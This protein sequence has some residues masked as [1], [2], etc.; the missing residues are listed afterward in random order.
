MSSKPLLDELR[1]EEK[2]AFNPRVLRR[3]LAYLKPYKGVVALGLFGL[4]ISTAATLLSPVIIQRTVDRYILIP[5]GGKALDQ[6]ARLAGIAR[7]SWFYLALLVLSLL[8]TFF[9]VYLT[10]LTS[11]NVMRDMR[12]DLF[13]RL[14]GQSMKFLGGTPVGSLV[15]RLTSDVEKINDFFTSVALAVLKDAALMAGILITLFIMNA[16]LALIVV[17]TLP[18]VIVLTLFIRNRVRDVYRAYQHHTSR[19]NAYISESVGGMDVVQLFNRAEGFREGFGERNG[20]L[21][22][23]SMDEMRLYSLFRPLVSFFTSLSL[24]CLIYFGT[25]L[26][27]SGLVTLGVLIAFI[28]LVE[29]FYQ[30][31][32]DITELITVMQSAMA[33]GE[34][35]FALM[36]RDESIPDEGT[37]APGEVKG[38]LAFDRVRFCYKENEPVLRGLSFQVKAG[39]TLAIVGTTGAGKTTVANLLARFWDRQEGSISLDGRDIRDYSLHSLRNHIQSVQQDVTLF[40]GTVRENIALGKDISDEEIGRALEIVR[41]DHFVKELP[42]GLDTTL[43]EGADNISAGQRQLL[44]FARIFVHNPSVVILDEATSSI[45]TQTETWIQEGMANLL[46]DRTALVI[47]HRLSTIRNADR[48]LV[49]GKGVLLEEGSHQELIDKGGIYFNLYKLQYE[50]SQEG[51]S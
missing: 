44:S 24:G 30:P 43:T 31:I 35:V 6:A 49:L 21:F 16:R 1:E 37:W 14:I 47:A 26:H 48:I 23:A 25:G 33:G 29:Q 8:F 38:D 51:D 34:R 18:P 9:Q 50:Q 7:N 10:A 28:N 46:R 22:K 5:E 41:A 45:D 11:Q 42:Y 39:E 12:R 3:I 20:E 15:S 32:R 17:V 27:N 2:G 4:I 36:D 40:A 13:D 19:V